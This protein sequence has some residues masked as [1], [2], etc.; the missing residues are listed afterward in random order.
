M[1]CLYWKD[2][3]AGAVK[4]VSTFSQTPAIADGATTALPPSSVA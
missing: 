1:V 3:V 2:L 4:A